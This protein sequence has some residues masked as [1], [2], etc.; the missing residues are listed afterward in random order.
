MNYDSVWLA[1]FLIHCTALS[2]DI[3]KQTLWK[4]EIM[5][6][7]HGEISIVKQTLWNKHCETS[8]VIQTLWNKYCKI[9]VGNIWNRHEMIKIVEDLPLRGFPF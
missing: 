6:N 2:P 7:K 9:N 3:V 5:W 4:F 1:H 8:I